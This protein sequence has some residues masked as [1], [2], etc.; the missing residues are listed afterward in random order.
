[1][2]K[3]KNIPINQN[4]KIS[5]EGNTVIHN[6]RKKEKMEEAKFMIFDTY[7][8]YLLIIYF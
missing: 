4:S 3:E 8:R 7:F 6:M 2:D 1:M 5:K